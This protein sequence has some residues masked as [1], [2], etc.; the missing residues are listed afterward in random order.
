MRF[1][2]GRQAPCGDGV[3]DLAHTQSAIEIDEVDWK[4]HSDGMHGFA[5][6]DPQSGSWLEASA[7]EQ[8]FVAPGAGTGDLDA[9]TD[10]CVPRPVDHSNMAYLVNM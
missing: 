8:A 7:A 3:A 4:L 9:R 10:D 5:W 1:K 2:T 6:D